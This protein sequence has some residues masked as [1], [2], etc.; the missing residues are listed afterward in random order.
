MNDIL[1]IQA[2]ASLGRLLIAPSLPRFL[3]TH[4]GLR[5]QMSDGIGMGDTLA[6]GVDAAICVGSIPGANLVTRPI[7]T[8]RFVTCAS[9]ELI[10]IDGI[11]DSPADLAPARCI[12]LLEPG[13][14]RARDWVFRR[15]AVSYTISPAAPLAFS[16]ADSAVT[17]AVRGGGYAH[18]HGIAADRRIA[19]GL[20]QPVLEQWNEE[21][22][23][24]A[25]VHVRERAA[26]DAIA[27]FAAFV[28]GLLPP[29]DRP[30]DHDAV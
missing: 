11:P 24:V 5:V 1:R 12:A 14:H 17:A 23:P 19:A 9:P 15:G 28:A 2:P 25:I 10:D 4:P 7:G 26:S 30:N 18:V 3:H 29:S 21:S 27:A 16:D 8:I 13:M 22:Q 20:L 6:S